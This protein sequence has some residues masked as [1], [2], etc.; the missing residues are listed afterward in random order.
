MRG[1]RPAYRDAGFRVTSIERLAKHDLRSLPSTWA[2]RLA[3]GQKRTF[4]RLRAA[5]CD[6]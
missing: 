5:A 3:F 1:L 4:W 6:P 2:K